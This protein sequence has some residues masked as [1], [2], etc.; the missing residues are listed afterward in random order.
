MTTAVAGKTGA[1]ADA[2]FDSFHRLVTGD[3]LEGERLGRLAAFGGVAQFPVRVKC[4]TLAW[5]ALSSGAG[6]SRV[7]DHG[8]VAVAR[9][10]EIPEGELIAVDAPDGEPVCL[11]NLGGVIHALHDRCPHQGVPGSRPEP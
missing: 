8:F 7:I 1:E 2:I 4:A 10:D 9:T 6:A 5:H 3:A 11:V